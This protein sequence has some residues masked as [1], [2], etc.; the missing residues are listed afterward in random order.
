MDDALV[1]QPPERGARIGEHAF[2]VRR[3]DGPQGA[4]GDDATGIRLGDLLSA[5]NPA[6]CSPA[7]YGMQGSGAR[8]YADLP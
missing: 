8:T 4:A 5:T 1:L 7:G 3:T 2:Q 6:K